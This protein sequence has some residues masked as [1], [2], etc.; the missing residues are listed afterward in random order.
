MAA[1]SYKP[2]EFFRKQQ[3]QG[4]ANKQTF[5]KEGIVDVKGEDKN[6]ERSFE[7]LENDIANN[8]RGKASEK[9][10]KT[11]TH[12]RKTTQNQGKEKETKEV[13]MDSR[14]SRKSAKVRVRL[15]VEL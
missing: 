14:E 12:K 2:S 15:Q 5:S 3:L 7:D 9:C 4:I 8:D 1:S 10:T 11:R 13:F 6:K